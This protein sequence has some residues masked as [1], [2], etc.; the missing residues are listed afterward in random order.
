[1]TRI[2]DKL[3]EKIKMAVTALLSP[4]DPI[5]LIIMDLL[6][7]RANDKAKIEEKRK[8]WV[9]AQG[10]ADSN[11]Q[12]LCEAQARIVSLEAERDELRKQI[13]ASRK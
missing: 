4:S 2:T 13:E 7:D 6:F 11:Y 10:M 8:E 1:M 12:R 5:C 3:A 9:V